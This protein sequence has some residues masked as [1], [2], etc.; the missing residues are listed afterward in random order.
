MNLLLKRF[1]KTY[2][3]MIASQRAFYGYFMLGLNDAVPDRTLL[4][5]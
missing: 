5:L 2:E 4:L 3:S 1:L